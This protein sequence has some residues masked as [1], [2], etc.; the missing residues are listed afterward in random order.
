VDNVHKYCYDCA[1]SIIH[2]KTKGNKQPSPYKKNR[3]A[4]LFYKPEREVSAFRSIKHYK[5]M[6][7]IIVLV[8]AT[9]VLTIFNGCQK[10]ELNIRRLTDNELQPQEVVKPDVYVEN[11]Y[12]AFKNMSA[13][14]SVIHLLNNMTTSEK[15][16]WE[17]QM[18]FK[19]ARADFDVLFDEYEKIQSP[20]KF[21]AFKEKNKNKL[22]FNESDPDDYSVDYPYATR[23]FLPILNNEGVYKVGRSIIKYTK[24]DQIVIADGDTKKLKNIYAHTNDKNVIMMPKL[25]STDTRID[26]FEDNDPRTGRNDLWHTKDGISDRRLNNQL[27]VEQY[28]NSFFDYNVNMTAWDNGIRVMLNQR[29]QKHTILGWKDYYTTYGITEIKCKVGTFPT[30]EDIRIHI[31]AEVKPSIDFTLAHYGQITYYQPSSYLSIPS[32]SF[33]AKVTFRGFGFDYSDYYKIDHPDTYG[34]GGSNNY[35]SPDWGW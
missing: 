29:G 22:E 2:Y 18:G 4:G 19:S 24:E 6:K 21:L 13:V 25:K 10:E 14:D 30:Y 12:L 1:Y 32:I 26:Y 34:L 7:K 31:S 27:Y 17:S 3:V 9:A 20:E 15:E 23:Y 16:V 35:P 11:G 33:A 28:L 8:M 5:E